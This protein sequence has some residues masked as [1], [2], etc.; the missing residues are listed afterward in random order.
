E[1]EFIPRPW[2]A[3]GLRVDDRTGRGRPPALIPHVNFEYPLTSYVVRITVEHRQ[4]RGNRQWL[5]ETGVIF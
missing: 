4:Q 2:L 3:L 5:L 1:T